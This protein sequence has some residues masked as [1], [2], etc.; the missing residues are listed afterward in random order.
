MARE[1]A[2]RSN[3]DYV[4]GDKVLIHK[5]GNLRKAETWY[6]GPYTVTQ[7]HMDG[8][9]RVQHITCTEQLNIRRVTPYHLSGD[10]DGEN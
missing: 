3:Y 5:D 10:I 7:V 4:I 6:D 8:T 2:Q 1:N 9:I